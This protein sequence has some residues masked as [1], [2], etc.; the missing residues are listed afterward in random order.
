[1][2]SE[3]YAETAGVSLEEAEKSV[4]LYRERM[5]M[6]VDLWGTYK[7]AIRHAWQTGQRLRFRIPPGRIIDYGHVTRADQP[8]RYGRPQYLVMM[9]R[10][11]SKLTPIRIHQG[12]IV[13]NM[14]QALA[15]NIFCDALLRLEAAG[16]QTILHIHDEVLIDISEAEAETALPRVVE[17]MSTAPSW[18]PEI[19]LA[20]EGSVTRVY[21]K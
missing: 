1:M 3:R 14:A 21:T 13:E 15:R 5:T 16:F 10:K 11:G 7:N 8:D 12:V 4:A 2:G 19:P 18:L 9:Q 6:V 20:A 17:I